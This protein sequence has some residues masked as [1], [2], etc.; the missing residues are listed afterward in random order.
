M[1]EVENFKEEL[2]RL[3]TYAKENENNLSDKIIREY[4]SNLELTDEQWNLIYGY[5]EMNR[6]NI[7]NHQPDSGFLNLYKKEGNKPDEEDLHTEDNELQERL[8]EEQTK[9]FLRYQAE[10]ASIRSLTKEEELNLIN[11][12][13]LGD[14][15][16]L[17]PLIRSRLPMVLE[18]VEGFDESHIYREDLVQEGNMALMTAITTFTEGD[19]D[20][21]LRTAV[22]TAVKEFIREQSGF[23]NLDSFISE[24]TNL[25][26]E[27]STEMAKE[28][29][30]EPDVAELSGRLNLPPKTVEELMKISL[31]AISVVEAHGGPEEEEIHHEGEDDH[32]HSCDCGHHH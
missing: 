6:I 10:V 22:E 20:L 28:L 27:I 23:D 14:P 25:L 7:E 3:V 8:A 4:F 31:N 2:G 1:R 32:G 16:A 24:Q 18:I 26:L 17:E 29:G 19:L 13:T 9:N 21:H 30:R 11:R 5:L 12:Y 15:G